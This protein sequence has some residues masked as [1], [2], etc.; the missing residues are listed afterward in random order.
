M[1]F[2]F[3]GKLAWTNLK[4]NRQI[5]YPYMGTTAGIIAMFYIL[6]HLN[7]DQEVGSFTCGATLQVILGL[8]VIVVGI[9]SVIFLFYLNSFLMKRRKTELGLYNVLGMGK[10]HIA[11]V[12]LWENVYGGGISMILGLTGGILFSKVSQLVLFRLLDMEANYD[13]RIYGSVMAKTVILFGLIYVLLYVSSLY[14][15]I[16]SSARELLSSNAA[17]EKEPKANFVIALT[18]LVLLGAGYIIAQLITDPFAA[19]GMFFVAVILVILG[20]YCCFIAG[21]VALFKI[22]RKNKNYYYKTNHFV[23]VSS[24]IYRMKRNGA[25]LASICI[26]STMVLVMLSS[27]ACMYLGGGDAV[28]QAYPRE[29]AVES[30][31]RNMDMATYQETVRCIDQWAEDQCEKMGTSMDDLLRYRYCHVFV[32]MEG[33]NLIMASGMDYGEGYAFVQFIPLKDY[34]RSNHENRT[35]RRDEVLIYTNTD[36]KAENLNFEGCSFKVVETSDTMEMKIKKNSMIGYQVICVILPDDKSLQE[37]YEAAE[38]AEE[39]AKD[40]ATATYNVGMEYYLGFNTDLDEKAEDGLISGLQELGSNSQDGNYK[41]LMAWFEKQHMEP[42]FG[43]LYITATGSRG[44]REDFYGMYGGFFFLGILLSITFLFATVLIM[45]Y[46]Q[47][48]EGYEDQDRFEILKKVGM[49]DREIKK[50]INSQVLTVFFA[51]LLLAGLHIT[52]AF[53]MISLML[54]VFAITNTTLLI[55]LTIGG[56]LV[57]AVF[58]IVIYMATSKVYYRLVGGSR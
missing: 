53:H 14:Q 57:F 19:I 46:K 7:M 24:M 4:K 16:K 58:Y 52:F 29:I 42:V 34:N 35:L 13:F 2:G 5:Y 22:L 44:A 1:N 55:L 27:T 39:K 15:I 37:V 10:V 12:L 41:P 3:Y 48:T 20:T 28:E 50:S 45:Y 43:S 56:F 18:G 49:T 32:R 17:G 23:S 38:K 9:F 47:I 11:R 31:A 21:S 36:F 51:P 6:A 8:G 26:L 30:G 33:E 40:D 25:G 54:S